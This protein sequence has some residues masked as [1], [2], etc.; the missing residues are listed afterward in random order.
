MCP[1]LRRLRLGVRAFC[2]PRR[3]A[4]VVGWLAPRNA[5]DSERFLAWPRGPRPLLRKASVPRQ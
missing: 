3:K 1:D 2:F 4:K 5:P